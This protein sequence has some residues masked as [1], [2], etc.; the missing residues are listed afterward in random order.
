MTAR[1]L[2]SGCS[3]IT[4]LSNTGLEYPIFVTASTSQLIL[5]IMIAITTCAALQ[6]YAVQRVNDPMPDA[7]GAGR[8]LLRSSGGGRAL[9]QHAAI[10]SMMSRVAA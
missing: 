6:T 3:I 10:F 8:C 5:K 7:A 4:D 9:A 1:F 2:D